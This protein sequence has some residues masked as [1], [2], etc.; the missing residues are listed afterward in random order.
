VR[1]PGETREPGPN[2]IQAVD[3]GRDGAM[4]IAWPPFAKWAGRAG[5]RRAIFAQSRFRSWKFKMKP[6][7]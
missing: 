1:Q 6:E 3:D 4:A 7:D 5:W 2:T